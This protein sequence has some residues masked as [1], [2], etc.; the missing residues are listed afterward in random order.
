MVLEPLRALGVAMMLAFASIRSAALETRAKNI[1]YTP[2]I[3]SD[4]YWEKHEVGLFRVIGFD[5]N[6]EGKEQV[7]LMLIRSFSGRPA[8][9]TKTVPL[10]HLW[11]GPLEGGVPLIEVNNLLIVHTSKAGPSPLVANVVA[12]DPDQSPLVKRL[13][14][15]ADFR[16]A[17]SAP[18]ELLNGAFDRDRVIALYCL[19]RL[20]NHPP[21]SPPPDYIARLREQQGNATRDAQVRLM[22]N[23]LA[24]M[25][26]EK[27]PNSE[28][29]YRWLQS[30]ISQSRGLDWR[31]LRF[32]VERLLSLS[33]RRAQNQVFLCGL[34]KD[35]TREESIRVAAYSAFDDLFDFA[36]PDAGSDRIFDTC[37]G[38]LKDRTSLMR[39]AG[40]ALLFNLSGQIKSDTQYWYV[41]RAK[42]AIT[43]ALGR[44]FDDVTR[45]QL[46][47]YL[48]LISKGG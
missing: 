46:Q 48:A 16:A 45:M 21:S 18:A 5:T 2:D 3:T 11:F 43:A 27:L 12:G 30:A 28:E 47:H 19:R 23:D 40:A 37:V 33:R 14:R 42:S 8:E 39:R 6:A 31:Q 44:E 24:N 13:S 15:I 20:L 38:M 1:D 29:E 41:N 35:T 22:S 36:H 9:E 7:T 4:A 34:V 10:A 17:R 26:E 25:L 32:L